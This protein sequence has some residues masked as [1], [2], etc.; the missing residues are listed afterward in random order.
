MVW[1]SRASLPRSPVATCA[2]SS[3]DSSNKVYSP[4]LA[5]FPVCACSDTH[6]PA[7]DPRVHSLL[8]A[9]QCWKQVRMRTILILSFPGLSAERDTMSMLT[10]FHACVYACICPCIGCFVMFQY[11]HRPDPHSNTADNQARTCRCLAQVKARKHV[12]QIINSCA[13]NHST[14]TWVIFVLSPAR[15][16]WM[17]IMTMYVYACNVRSAMDGYGR[18]NGSRKMQYH[19][20]QPRLSEMGRQGQTHMFEHT[21]NTNYSH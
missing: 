12:K 16:A 6:V 4:F 1:S 13:G 20:N 18:Q 15:S 7:S 19:A 11:R 17:R 8:Q 9:V 14:S 10:R 2:P 3:H 21:S 5:R